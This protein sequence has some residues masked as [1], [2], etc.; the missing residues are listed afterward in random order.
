M[1]NI[2]VRSFLRAS[3]TS[4]RNALI[5]LA[6][7]N[8]RIA[9]VFGRLLLSATRRIMP[10]VRSAV[11]QARLSRILKLHARD[12]LKSGGFRTALRRCSSIAKFLPRQINASD[13][14]PRARCNHVEGRDNGLFNYRAIRA[15]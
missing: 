13:S 1:S 14:P 15:R 10:T 3:I 5:R 4:N 7:I 11:T 6:E 8:P 12:W 9:K 2:K